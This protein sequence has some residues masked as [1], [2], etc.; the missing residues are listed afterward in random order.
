MADGN[1]VEETGAEDNDKKYFSAQF[2]RKDDA[3]FIDSVGRLQRI[4]GFSMREIFVSGVD[5]V[6]KSDK[7]QKAVKEIAA[8]A[9]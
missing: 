1:E 5:A 3:D 7:Y 6:R 9:E 4:G 8:E 2:S